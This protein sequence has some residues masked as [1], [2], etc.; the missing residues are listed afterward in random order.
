MCLSVP[1][2]N[3]VELLNFQFTTW[4][5]TEFSMCTCSATDKQRQE[6]GPQ[7]RKGKYE[8]AYV[9]LPVGEVQSFVLHKDQ[10]YE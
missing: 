3:G 1:T 5:A 7:E 4:L 10:Q 8:M 6:T 9:L 2:G